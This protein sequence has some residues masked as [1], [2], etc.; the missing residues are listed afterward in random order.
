MR[1]V[2]P[3]IPPSGRSAPA[4][5]PD[6]MN[7]PITTADA[8]RSEIWPWGH[9]MRPGAR[10]RS[11]RQGYVLGLLNSAFSQWGRIAVIAGGVAL[12]FALLAAF[13]KPE[14]LAS[15]NLLVLSSE[16]Y[17]NSATPLAQS[18]TY[19]AMSREAILGSEIAILTSSVVVREV[20]R[21]IGPGRLYPEVRKNAGV[22]AFAGHRDDGDELELA[23]KAFSEKLRVASNRTGGSIDIKYRHADPVLAA[24]AVNALV[25]EYQVR[26][27]QIYRSADAPLV[28]AT[29]ARAKD[30][31][32][33]LSE[34]LASFQAKA[35]IS[36]FDMQL[37]LVLRR[38]SEQ[39]KQLQNARTESAEAER[40]LASLTAQL[41]VT[42]REVVQYS[43]SETDKRVQSARDVLADLKKQE[44]QLRE[45]YTDRSE[46]V[47]TITRQIEAVEKEIKRGSAPASP[48]SV[49][50]GISEVRTAI[51]LALV[52]A[53][54]DSVALAR[55]REE[56]ANQVKA[57][58][59]EVMQ[60]QE[61]RVTHDAIARQKAL[62][63]QDYLTTT[64][65][66]QARRA[67]EEIGE[68][69]AP[70]VRVIQPAEPPPEPTRLRLALVVSG[71]L[72]S[73]VAAVVA[74]VLGYRFRSTYI[75]PA[76]LEDEQG[77]P[78]LARISD[79]RARLVIASFGAD[80]RTPTTAAG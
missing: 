8:V 52:K 64:K 51:E 4:T 72:L 32:D 71:L 43:D 60:L 17:A 16:E 40:R 2:V 73:A 57:I 61:L 14:Y 55:R 9:V 21:A 49:R 68:K 54:S 79:G 20:V 63:E 38:L 50:R 56:L 75:T 15:A 18:G 53:R 29:V 70:N 22:A 66:Y 33:R 34:E 30:R 78:V 45:T 35:Q 39:V 10:P 27:A 6:A 25:A 46:K 67:A 5:R 59:T 80:R 24:Q 47:V 23:T 77:L 42:P 58:E 62:A 41:E 28:E 7:G 48:S 19:T 11:G 65:A 31:L 12:A 44:S 1:D 26:R 13:M 36:N 3:E 69:R 74:G 37:D 76:R